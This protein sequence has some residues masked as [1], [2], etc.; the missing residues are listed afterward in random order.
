[1]KRIFSAS[2]FTPLKNLAT[3][4]LPSHAFYLC[5]F[6]LLMIVLLP[7]AS[8]QAAPNDEKQIEESRTLE[9]GKPIEREITGGQFHF[10]QVKVNAGQYL[11]VVAEQK[12]MDIVVALIKPDGKQVLEVDTPDISTGPEI[13]SLVAEAAGTYRFKVRT[14][15]E[16][17]G[18][19]RYEIKIAELRA[20][21]PEDKIRAA[22]EKAFAEGEELRL[23]WTADSLKSSL[24]KYYLALGLWRQLNDKRGEGTT[25]NILGLVYSNLGARPK[26]MEYF[27][28]ALHARHAAQD[29][30]GEIQTLNNLGTSYSAADAPQK[31][32]EYYE[33]AFQ[34]NTSL[35]DKSVEA[36]LLTNAG[37][38]YLTMGQL[39]KALEYFEQ[40]LPLR[41]AVGDRRG[42]AITL[43]SI[44]WV[45]AYLNE[46]QKALAYYQR[47]LTIWQA[48]GIRREEAGTLNDIGGA[49]AAE[50]DYQ[51]ALGYY[52]QVVRLLDLIADPA[53]RAGTMMGVGWLLNQTN[54][55]REALKYYQEALRIYQALNLRTGEAYA[56]NGMS[57]AYLR[58]GEHRRAVDHLNQ[59]Q[60]VF[61][62]TKDLAGKSDALAGLMLNWQWLENPR[63]S[64]LYGKLAINTLQEIRT[65]IQG[66]EKR[67][68]KSFLKTWEELYRHL[69]DL[70]ITEG[71]LAEAQQVLDMLKEEEYF[72]FVRRDG[73]EGSSLSRRANM[74]S[75]ENTV[76]TR[77]RQLA[78]QTIALGRERGELRNKSSLTPEEEQRLTKI[79]SELEL[80]GQAFQQFLDKLAVEIKR[81]P[82]G[83]D[84]I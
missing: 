60:A 57:A 46:R 48:Q 80:A 2:L 25:L 33:Q 38:V 29:R 12:G 3:L 16:R 6:V 52:Y 32:L 76:E 50:G 84:R 53:I 20:S 5:T 77:Y 82:Q 10:Y 74:T 28:Q 30:G 42:E 72:E 40:A 34:L 78:A 23:K 13:V 69:A 11:R 47:A 58:L 14:F 51:T 54:E 17:T 39:K 83:G 66:L 19:G 62:E 56:L 79:E 70:L 31:A 59:A 64:I 4:S 35:G 22:A 73:N 37:S 21:L 44:G 41:Q 15:G 71:R 61:S 8:T 1:M 24:E 18:I 55:F 63:L 67:L 65:N 27:K 7:V 68:Q 75:T 49:Y 45:H 81:A 43:Q 36:F 9:P 26:A